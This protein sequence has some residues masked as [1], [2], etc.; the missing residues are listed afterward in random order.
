VVLE[1]RP[2]GQRT[3]TY[4]G[5]DVAAKN[6]GYLSEIAQLV[7]DA[8]FDWIGPTRRPRAGLRS[9]GPVDFATPEGRAVV[10]DHDILITVG[11]ADSNPTTVIEA[12]AWG[13]LPVCTAESGYRGYDGITNVPLDDAAGA[14]AVLRELQALPADEFRARQEQNWQQVGEWFTWDRF[15]RQVLDAL[16]GPHPGPQRQLAPSA[17]RR[18]YARWSLTALGATNRAGLRS[19]LVAAMRRTSDRVRS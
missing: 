10:A 19:S 3:F 16:A 11:R 13:L 14:A 2:P 4:I 17:R 8:T 7:P 18:L 12:M 6:L 5:R 9:V 15:A 1:P